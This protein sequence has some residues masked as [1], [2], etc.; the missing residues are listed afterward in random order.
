[1]NE[2][3]LFHGTSFANSEGIARENFRLDKVGRGGRESNLPNK[4]E[5]HQPN[6]L[7]PSFNKIAKHAQ[8]HN[9]HITP[10]TVSTIL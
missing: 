10:P 6:S 7:V 3:L 2:C 8:E 1:V 9:S 5:V 4:C